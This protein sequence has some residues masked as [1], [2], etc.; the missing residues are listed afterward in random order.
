MSQFKIV[1]VTTTQDYALPIHSNGSTYNG[2]PVA[3]LVEQWFNRESL[4]R[5]HISR[6]SSRVGNS[7][8]MLSVTVLAE[9]LT[10]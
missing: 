9:T 6:E 2:Q 8:E 1:R 5:H 3:E 7:I 4:N 10:T